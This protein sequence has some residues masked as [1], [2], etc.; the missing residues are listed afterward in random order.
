MLLCTCSQAPGGWAE[1][2]G[3]EGRVPKQGVLLRKFRGKFEKLVEY[4]KQP[5]E[6]LLGTLGLIHCFAWLCFTYLLF[7]FSISLFA[8]IFVSSH[9]GFFDLLYYLFKIV[10][11]CCIDLGGQEISSR[12][13]KWHNLIFN[14]CVASTIPTRFKMVPGHWHSG[15]SRLKGLIDSPIQLDLAMDSC[16]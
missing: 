5:K 14:M 9:L 15:L 7:C 13:T 6:H 16:P 11:Y 12:P 4:F 3:Y 1:L 10:V 2:Q 8:G